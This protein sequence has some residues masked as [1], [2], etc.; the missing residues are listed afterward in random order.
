LTRSIPKLKPKDSVKRWRATR[1]GLTCRDAKAYARQIEAAFGCGNPSAPRNWRHEKK[2]SGTYAHYIID[3]SGDGD[4]GQ[5]IAVAPTPRENR[6][7][8]PS[9]KQKRVCNAEEAVG[10]A[11]VQNVGH[12][13]GGR[14][15]I[16]LQMNAGTFGA[17]VLPEE[18]NQ[19][20]T[21]SAQWERAEIAE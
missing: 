16:V 12:M 9:H 14:H 1:A 8:S 5:R 4:P 7:R 2:E 21:S 3:I 15:H 20:A 17:P 6:G 13:L 18:Y 11:N 19:N 10:F